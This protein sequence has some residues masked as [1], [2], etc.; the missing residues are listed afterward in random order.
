LK[1]STIRLQ[2][3]GPLTA[4]T[5][6]V[7][8]L[9]DAGYKNKGLSMLDDS[10][11]YFSESGCYEPELLRLRAELLLLQTGPATAKPSEDLFRQALD[12]AHQQGA[13]S[14]ELR[15][16]TSLAQLLND[17]GHASDAIA[18]LEPVYERFTEGFDTSDLI[19]AKRLLS[20]LGHRVPRC[21]S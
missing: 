2:T 20:E 3:S 15:A 1:K 10:A 17:Q 9:A 11:A 6:Y 8:A 14:W 5:A 13:S 12:F 18:C 19:A 21:S 16:A 4:L 7:E